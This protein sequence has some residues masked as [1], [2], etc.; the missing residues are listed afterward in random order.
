MVQYLCDCE[1]IQEKEML[2][3]TLTKHKAECRVSYVQY[4]QACRYA[5]CVQAYLRMH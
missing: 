2:A 3:M 4:L 1:V 5:A